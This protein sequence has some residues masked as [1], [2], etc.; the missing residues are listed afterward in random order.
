MEEP[1]VEA[2]VECR[3]RPSF[4]MAGAVPVDL[5]TLGACATNLLDRV[6]D[7]DVEWPDDMPGFEDYVWTA[8]AVLLAGGAIY[9]ATGNRNGRSKAPPGRSR[10]RAGRVGGE[11]CRPTLLMICST[12]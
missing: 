7:L 4:P 6:G 9:S 8:A 3:S 11:E 10:L 2:I 5:T 12:S 1:V